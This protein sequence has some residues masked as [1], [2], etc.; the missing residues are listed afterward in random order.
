MLRLPLPIVLAV[1][2]VVAAGS[3]LVNMYINADK[4]YV[5]DVRDLQLSQSKA[6]VLDYIP[7]KVMILSNNSKAWY[8]TEIYINGTFVVIGSETPGYYQ[9]SYD[10]SR[11]LVDANRTLLIKPID[12]RST[13]VKIVVKFAYQMP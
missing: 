13:R 11:R 8:E 4:P 7:Y 2:A 1:I 5:I 10:V 3:V 12:V 9:V 6:V